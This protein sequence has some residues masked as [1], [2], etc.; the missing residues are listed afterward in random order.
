MSRE[1]T[2]KE[3]LGDSPCVFVA[4]PDDETLWAGGLIAATSYLNWSAV[5][6]S[7]PRLDSVRA[8]FWN[9]A[10]SVLGIQHRWLWPVIESPPSHDLMSLPPVM[11]DASCI[12]THGEK[13][14]YGHRHHKQVNKWIKEIWAGPTM[15]FGGKDGANAFNLS[16]DLTEQKLSALKCYCH[17]TPYNNT[18][19]PKWQALLDCYVDKAGYKLNQETFD[20][21]E[22]NHEDRVSLVR[23]HGD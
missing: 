2:L 8:W 15:T 14:E 12:V 23:E 3:V 17:N 10:C 20:I 1:Q 19:M 16:D 11:T 21:W 5:C 22:R 13:G 9:H 7:I 6:C 4:H 18:I